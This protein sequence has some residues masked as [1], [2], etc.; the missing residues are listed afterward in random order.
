MGCDQY[1]GSVQSAA[2]P[3]TDIAL[4]LAAQRTQAANDS[5]VEPAAS[6]LARLVR[7]NY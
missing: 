1:Q 5:L 4:L 6:R 7:S 2:V 3:A